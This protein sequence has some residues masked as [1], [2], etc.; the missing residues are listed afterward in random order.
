MFLV[1]GAIGTVGRA[2]VNLL[3]DEGAQ[4]RAITRNPLAAIC[5]LVSPSLRTTRHD[6]RR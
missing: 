6:P 5:R 2:L 1:A 3:A 4:V